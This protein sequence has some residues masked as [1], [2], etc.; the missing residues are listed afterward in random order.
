MILLF[1]HALRLF[2]T[3][4]CD[5]YL[6]ITLPKLNVAAVYNKVLGSLSCRSIVRA[7]DWLRR[8]DM[9]IRTEELNT[10]SGH[11]AAPYGLGGSATRRFHHRQ[12]PRT[13]P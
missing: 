12:K 4:T 10:I 7:Q 1:C 8:Y 3:W 6:P 2:H 13:G 11:N 9:T 5:G